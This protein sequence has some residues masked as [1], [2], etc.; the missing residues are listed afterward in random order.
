M[1]EDFL[2]GTKNIESFKFKAFK[3]DTSFG[4]ERKNHSDHHTSLDFRL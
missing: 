3:F 2:K 1:L 4:K